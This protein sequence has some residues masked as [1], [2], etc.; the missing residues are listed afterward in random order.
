M[1]FRLLLIIIA[2]SL[3]TGCYGYIINGAGYKEWIAGP[4]NSFNRY[5][6]TPEHQHT[7]GERYRY[8]VING[9]HY[10]WEN[11]YKWK[12]HQLNRYDYLYNKA[13]EQGINPHWFID[14]HFSEDE[15]NTSN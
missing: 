11:E 13:L 14:R 12:E 3:F 9:S 7:R 10:Y 1:K 15:E 5:R 2:A 8:Y 4:D 6:T